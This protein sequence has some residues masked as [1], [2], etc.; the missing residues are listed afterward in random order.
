MNNEDEVNENWRDVARR[1]YDIQTKKRDEKRVVSD[2]ERRESLLAFVKESISD[3]IKLPPYRALHAIDHIVGNETTLG[4]DE[5]AELRRILFLA[6][7]G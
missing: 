3:G 5:C 7:A 2:H 6:L 1:E 4:P